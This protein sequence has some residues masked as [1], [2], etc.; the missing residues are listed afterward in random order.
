MAEKN[1]QVEVKAE[2]PVK[3]AEKKKSS[4]PNV[5][6]RFGAWLRTCKAELKKIVWPSATAVR[7]NTIMVIILMVAFAALTG[8]VDAIFSKFIYILGVL[9]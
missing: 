3:K 2:A 8:A 6:K 5:F 1:E 7:N 9:I 4:K